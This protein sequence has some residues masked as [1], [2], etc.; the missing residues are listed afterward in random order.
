[1]VSEIDVVAVD[2]SGAAG[3]SKA[4]ALAYARAGRLVSLQ[5]GLTRAAVVRSIID[6]ADHTSSLVVALD[7][8][9]SLPCWWLAQERF[10]SAPDLWQRVATD[11]ERWLA[12]CEPPWWGRPGKP[13]PDLPGHFRRTEL[14]TAP[15]AGIRPKSVFQIGGAGSVG[16]GSL[17][18][19]PWLAKLSEAGFSIWPFDV[20][21]RPPVVVEIWPRLFTGPVAK[22]SPDAR[23]TALSGWSS[24]L[25]ETQA[26]HAASSEDAFD[27][28]V[29]ALVMSD[30]GE[31]LVR[32]PDASFDVERIEGAIWAPS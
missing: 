28:V 21:A 31:E 32:L 20:P 4:I 10:P 7:F 2:W 16:T 8:A 29:S 6:L 14:A 30:H 15:V 9:F 5:V 12:A 3:S 1:M 23:R 17:R 18:G 25:T 26:E 13:R 22:R 24:R 11:G 19:M 27:A